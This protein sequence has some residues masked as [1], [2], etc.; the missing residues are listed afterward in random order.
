MAKKPRRARTKLMTETEV[1][2]FSSN[3]PRFE[4][5]CSVDGCKFGLDAHEMCVYFE[6]FVR[7]DDGEVIGIRCARPDED[8]E[9]EFPLA[10][11]GDC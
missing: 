5:Y 8:A 9:S 3:E 7:D 11:T 6:S 1:D 10:G 2:G 4:V